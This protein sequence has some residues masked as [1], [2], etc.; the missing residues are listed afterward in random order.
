[1]KYEFS[2]LLTAA[3]VTEQQADK[4]YEAGCDDGSILSRGAFTVLQ[5]DRVAPTLDEALTSAIRQVESIGLQVSRVEI[6]RSEVPV[7]A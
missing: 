6:E 1:M 4:L 2:L 7:S 3:D 5:L